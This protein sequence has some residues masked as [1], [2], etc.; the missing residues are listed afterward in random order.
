LNYAVGEDVPAI[1][2]QSQKTQLRAANS[3]ELGNG[4]AVEHL[5]I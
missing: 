3:M 4:T 5:Q 2:P 1:D